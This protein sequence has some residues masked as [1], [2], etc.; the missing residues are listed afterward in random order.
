PKKVL[1]ARIKTLSTRGDEGEVA[2][3]GGF[4]D[5]SPRV[6][7]LFCRERHVL[8]VTGELVS[9]AIRDKSTPEELKKFPWLKKFVGA[10]IIR[11][12]D[13][14][15]VHPTACVWNALLKSGEQVFFR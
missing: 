11:G 3:A 9:R 13:E 10:N 1:D 15:F 14:G 12:F 4:F 7:D 8:P 5:N 2:M 6:I